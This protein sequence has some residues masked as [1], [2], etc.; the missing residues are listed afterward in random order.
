LARSGDEDEER[1]RA[2]EKRAAGR[3]RRR[4]VQALSLSAFSPL[5]LFSF[6][7]RLLTSAEHGFDALVL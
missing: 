2:I 4:F 7:P 6:C 1:E 5:P 3:R